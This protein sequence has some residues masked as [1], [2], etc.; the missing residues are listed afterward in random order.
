MRLDALA[1]SQDLV[2]EDQNQVDGD[3]QISRDE[4]LVVEGANEG[5]EVL[6]DGNEDAS[7]EG[8]I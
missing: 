5:V 6:S 2:P 8:T 1:L 3:T 7:T 4:R